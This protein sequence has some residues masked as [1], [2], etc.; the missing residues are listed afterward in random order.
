MH[1]LQEHQRKN[2][3]KLK[4]GKRIFYITLTERSCQYLLRK[5]QVMSINTID[6]SRVR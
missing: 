6:K 1:N 3:R 4:L 2:E 5:F